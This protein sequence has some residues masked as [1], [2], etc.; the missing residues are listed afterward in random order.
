MKKRIRGQ[1]LLLAAAMLVFLGLAAG[2]PDGRGNLAL[3]SAGGAER[4]I[5]ENG[6]SSPAQ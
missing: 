6:G 5:F 3:E 2:G 1:Y 4:M